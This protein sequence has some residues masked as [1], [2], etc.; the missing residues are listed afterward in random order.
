MY[1]NLRRRKQLSIYKV[2][3]KPFKGT[4]RFHAICMTNDKHILMANE[5]SCYCEICVRGIYC[6]ACKRQ[7]FNYEVETVEP[8]EE[9]HPNIDHSEKLETENETSDA[10]NNPCVNVSNKEEENKGDETLNPTIGSFV[11]AIY[12][13]EWYIGQIVGIDDED[14]EI[15]INFMSRAKMLYKWPTVVYGRTDAIFYVK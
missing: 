10:S 9:S 4:M 7:T 8:S 13:Q 5:K 1:Q 14:D 12:E 15:D 11:A 2:K 3:A 6:D